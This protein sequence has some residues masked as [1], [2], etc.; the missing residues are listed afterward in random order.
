MLYVNG[1]VMVTACLALLSNVFLVLTVALSHSKT[2]YA[3][4]F[5]VANLSLVQG[6][7]SLLSLLHGAMILHGTSW[8]W[9]LLLVRNSSM[10]F[11]TA[12]CVSGAASISW[13]DWW[14]VVLVDGNQ[15]LPSGR[16]M[17]RVIAAVLWSLMLLSTVWLQLVVVA[18]GG[19]RNFGHYVKLYS[20]VF[21]AAV[22][23]VLFTSCAYVPSV[24]LG[25]DAFRQ[26]RKRNHKC[27]ADCLCSD[28]DFS[29]SDATVRIEKSREPAPNVSDPQVFTIPTIVTDQQSVV[30]LIRFLLKIQ[31]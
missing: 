3:H 7:V 9:I 13:I 18:R 11:F 10:G 24:V 31:F 30:N 16:R 14:S 28:S 4:F 6:L 2:S 26:G 27:N 5:A 15:H 29:L 25:T 8:N 21:F 19:Q 22:V 23:W 1:V 17:S 20:F 12:G